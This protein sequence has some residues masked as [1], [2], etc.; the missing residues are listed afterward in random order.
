MILKEM[1][2][3]L[4]H[5]LWRMKC[6]YAAAELNLEDWSLAAGFLRNLC[7]DH[8][9]GYSSLSALNDVDLVYFDPERTDESAD[10][11]FQAELEQEY[12]EI[13][14]SVKNQARMHL[15]NNHPP[16]LNTLHAMSFWPETATAIGVHLED[17]NIQLR[18]AYGFEDLLD[19]RI[20]KSPNC[21]LSDEFLTNRIE[22]KNWLQKWPSLM[23]D[24]GIT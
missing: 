15:R 14:W 10:L 12:P 2:N 23:V 4:R 16:Y 1:K 19:L 24:I 9:H 11:E 20:R 21:T 5:D 17:G 18:A 6:L 13:P 7:W 8:L 22:S 3:W